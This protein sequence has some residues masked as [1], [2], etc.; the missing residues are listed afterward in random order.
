MLVAESLLF[1]CVELPELETP[2]ESF[3]AAMNLPLGSTRNTYSPLQRAILGSQELRFGP[4]CYRTDHVSWNDESDVRFVAE[5]LSAV[6][7]AGWRAADL[8]GPDADEEL[9]YIQ[10]WFPRLVDLYRRA[11][12]ARWVIVCESL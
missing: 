5:S 7:T 1:S 11:V 8:P 2:L 9:E 12:E 6:P 3:S 10:E 4:I